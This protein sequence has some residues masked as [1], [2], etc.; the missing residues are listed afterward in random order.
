MKITVAKNDLK[1]TLAVAQNTLSTI[2][3]ITSHFVF[4]YRN[5]V[6]KVKTACPP[7]IFSMTPVTASTV[8]FTEGEEWDDFSIEGKRLLKALSATKDNESLELTFNSATKRVVLKSST[9][10]KVEFESLDPNNFPIWET[11]LDAME[12][13]DKVLTAE[14]LD[15]A[16][17]V[18]KEF[19]SKEQARVN[20]CLFEIEPTKGRIVASDGSSIL[21]AKHASFVGVDLKVFVK[22]LPSVHKFIKSYVGHNIRLKSSPQAQFLFTDDGAVLGLMKITHGGVPLPEKFDNLLDWKPYKAW[23][24]KKDNLV[25]AIKWLSSGAQA[26]DFRLVFNVASDPVTLFMGTRAGKEDLSQTLN[27]EP[28]PEDEDLPFNYKMKKDATLFTEIDAP[29]SFP[30]NYTCLERAIDTL[31]GDETFCFGVWVEKANDKIQG[32]MIVKLETTQG[33]K[34][35]MVSSWFK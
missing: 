29:N 11:Y 28:L 17:T 14:L 2:N 4:V 20:F 25:S 27:E 32:G 15:E 6:L 12:D 1:E 13:G 18:S 30:I 8:E 21:V 9:G 5:G 24:F 23:L 31:G 16:V 10:G 35:S 3:D 26:N 34:T 22:D 33:I 19:I 7:R